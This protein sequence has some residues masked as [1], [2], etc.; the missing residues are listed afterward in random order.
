MNDFVITVAQALV[1][2]AIVYVGSKL[3][4]VSRAIDRLD[5][6]VA[7]LERLFGEGLPSTGRR[8]PHAGTIEVRGSD[9]EGPGAS[10][11]GDR[12]SAAGDDPVGPGDC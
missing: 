2:I 4:R 3:E 8:F 5:Y 9:R 10:P 12:R 7:V 6:R 11:G 1:P